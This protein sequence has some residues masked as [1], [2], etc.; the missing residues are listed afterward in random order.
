M[1][2]HRTL[3]SLYQIGI[4]GVCNGNSFLQTTEEGNTSQ[5]DTEDQHTKARH[6]PRKTIRINLPHTAWHWKL[7]HFL[8]PHT[9]AHLK[10]K[11]TAPT[12]LF[13]LTWY[14][15]QVLGLPVDTG[16]LRLC[17]CYRL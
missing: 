12:L 7:V 9:S 11:V 10:E 3:H 15:G 16:F 8:P 14:A 6:P 17:P 5:I 1:S 13:R 4:C 2:Q